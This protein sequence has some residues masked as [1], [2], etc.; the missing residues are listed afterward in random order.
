[1]NVPTTILLPLKRKKTREKT[2]DFRS[3]TDL[4]AFRRNSEQIIQTAPV[5]AADW[6]H[7]SIL[8]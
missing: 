3:L 2:E 1:M 6:R 5:H 7:S 8:S 4:M